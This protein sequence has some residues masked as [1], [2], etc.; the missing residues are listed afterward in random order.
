MKLFK[1]TLLTLL[2]LMLISCGDNTTTPIITDVKSLE[3]EGGDIEIYSTD[4]TPVVATV[5]YMDETT[6]DATLSVKW[7]SDF[8]TLVYDS[9][10]IRGGV[11]NGGEDTLIAKHKDFNDSIEVKVHKLTEFHISSPDINTTGEHILQAEGSFDNNETNRSIV[12]NIVWS[13]DNDAVISVEDNI[14]TIEIEDGDTNV[15]ATVFGDTNTSSP[16]APKN[17]IYSIE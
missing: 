3:I 9:G 5:T 15:T 2:S 8:D 12:T 1:S 6:D 16:I 14:V 4:S 11:D 10:K 13:A 7:S 17:V